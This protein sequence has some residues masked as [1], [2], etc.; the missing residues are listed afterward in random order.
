MF[1]LSLDVYRLAIYLQ[2]T[3]NQ[4]REKERKNISRKTIEAERGNGDHLEFDL[5]TRSGTSLS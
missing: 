4:G 3:T 5:D 1:L 2:T